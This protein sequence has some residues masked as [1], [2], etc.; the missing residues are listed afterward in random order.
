MLDVDDRE[1]RSGICEALAALGVAFAVRRLP[2][3]DYVVDDMVFIERKTVADF[4]ESIATR[5]LFAQIARLRADHRR[6]VLVIEGAHLPGRPSVRGALCAIAVQWHMPILRSNNVQGTAWYIS[7][8]VKQHAATT[9][10]VVPYRGWAPRIHATPSQRML[11][12]IAG[13]GPSL[14]ATLLNHVGS[15]RGVLSA[16]EEDLQRVPGIG[17]ALARHILTLA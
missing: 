17:A 16:S 9:N 6:S 14:A 7:R 13:I 5:R 3:A 12:Q 2:L 11:M 8:I 10:A 15:V 4:L 1:Q